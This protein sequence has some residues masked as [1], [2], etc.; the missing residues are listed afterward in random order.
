MYGV[1]AVRSS[2]PLVTV[3]F[4]ACTLRAAM[5]DALVNTIRSFSNLAES[6]LAV[7]AP[8]QR[9]AH[10]IALANS[11]EAQIKG[12]KGCDMAEATSLNVSITE[13]TFPAHLKLQLGT[14]VHHR[15]LA[16]CHSEADTSR[17]Q[18]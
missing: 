16:P 13:S 11:I 1:D 12:L 3:H 5:A 6:Q 2:R 17:G 7:L 18:S 14:V 10:I 8:E 4:C 9:D 15:S